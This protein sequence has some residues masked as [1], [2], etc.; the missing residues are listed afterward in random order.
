MQTRLILSLLA[1]ASLP[2]TALAA[3]K[4]SASSS[5]DTGSAVHGPELA[6][7][8]YLGDALD[9]I[10]HHHEKLDGSS[11][12]DGLVADEIS[13]AARVMVVADIYDALVTAR[14][15]GPAVAPEEALKELRKEA[16][17]GK[18]DPNVVECLSEL[19]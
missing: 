6:F 9:V 2:A 19:I 7:G 17:E 4:L 8:H 13:M 16:L 14:S 1:A 18:I 11:Y 3:P 10:R 12:P 15:Y 5:H